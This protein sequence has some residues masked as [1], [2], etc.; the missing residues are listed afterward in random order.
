MMTIE[1]EIEH[2][3]TFLSHP[4]GFDVDMG[5]ILCIRPIDE[6]CPPTSWAVDWE[7]HIEGICYDYE[8][9]FPSLAEAVK[10]FVEKRHYMCNGLDFS[11]MACEESIDIRVE[12]IE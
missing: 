4:G 6:G 11:Q 2:L 12:V 9:L 7:E 10:F 8:K 3:M 1:E 5:G